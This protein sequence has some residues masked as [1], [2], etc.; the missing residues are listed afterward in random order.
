[1]Y[2][3]LQGNMTKNGH[4]DLNKVK[5]FDVLK[6]AREFAKRIN[7]DLK[8]YSKYPHGYLETLI[9]N[10]DIDDWNNPAY[11]VESYFFNY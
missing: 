7:H 4:G 8:G 6:E 1:M 5:S 3:V 2:T 9:V 11:I 10:D